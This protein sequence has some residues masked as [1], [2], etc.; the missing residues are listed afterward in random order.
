MP[1]S[2]DTELH[3]ILLVVCGLIRFA[4]AI[5]VPD[6]SAGKTLRTFVARKFTNYSIPIVL[7][8]DNGQP[9]VSEM[10]EAMAKYA[11]Y[12]HIRPLSY[13][14]QSNS[15]AEKSV[16]KRIS[17]LLVGHIHHLRDWHLTLPMITIALNMTVHS[18]TGRTPFFALFGRDTVPTSELEDADL[19]QPTFTACELVD[20]LALR[21]R[22]VWEATCA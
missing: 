16:N 7:K 20:S 4:I 1:R 12:W 5:P 2:L 9:F 15:P 11:G 21:L 22:R 19:Y 3:H 14:P 6:N 18:S 8:S 17:D 13:N 10:S